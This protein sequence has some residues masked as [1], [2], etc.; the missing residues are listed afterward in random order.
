MKNTNNLF[1]AVLMTFY[2]FNKSFILY[3]HLYTMTPWICKLTS[4]LYTFIF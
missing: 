1:D 3:I 4:P 2:V